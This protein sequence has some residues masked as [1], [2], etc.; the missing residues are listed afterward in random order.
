MRRALCSLSALLILALSLLIAGNAA[1]SGR[2]AAFSAETE[3]LSGS[4]SAAEGLTLSL[5]AS[6]A[7]QLYWGAD[8]SVGSGGFDTRFSYGEAID[9]R[10]DSSGRS[11]Y[12]VEFGAGTFFSGSLSDNDAVDSIFSGLAERA[13]A[14]GAGRYEDYSETI[15]LA[16]YFDY[17][18]VDAHAIP[19]SER[20]GFAEFFRVP[21]LPGDSI[22]VSVSGVT[23][24]GGASS[25]GMSS[26]DNT[27]YLALQSVETGTADYLAFDSSNPLA[28]FDFS[29][30]PGGFG[31]YRLPHDLDTGLPVS[32]GLECVYPL[33]PSQLYSVYLH[34][35]ND[36]KLL[37][38]AVQSLS[39][40]IELYVFDAA[41]PGE[42]LQ[43]LP[44]FSSA[45]DS[46][47]SVHF[48]DGFLV[49]I[50]DEV[51]VLEY[52]GSALSPALRAPYPW[53]QSQDG[54]ALFYYGSESSFAW[55][56]RRLA[57]AWLDVDYLYS[58]DHLSRRD[59][60]SLRVC[61]LDSSGVLY[62]GLLFPDLLANNRGAA[63]VSDIY[64]CACSLSF[65][66]VG[67]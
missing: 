28:D 3:P 58:D 25:R 48:Y 37:L 5:S 60:L 41:S 57:I 43:V 7:S 62:D 65:G 66:E 29:H 32:A 54:E 59:S 27:V 18:P 12:G 51:L 34:S 45:G 35:T 31:I 46:Y 17:Y 10:D 40:D 47:L 11:I 49:Y 14:A 9:C 64:N 61:V 30:I 56:G 16:D 26:N 52:D 4:P 42:P 19:S 39:G 44:L 50:C 20:E 8:Y 38:A 63:G 33:D 21:V 15:Y 36:G 67:I 24:G 13:L 2:A 53:E 22:D 55:D 1:L 23:P 6:L